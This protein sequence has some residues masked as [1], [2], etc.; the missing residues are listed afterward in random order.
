M[1]AMSMG[2]AAPEDVFIISDL[3]IGGQYGK[4][5][6][7]RGFRINTHVKELTGFLTEVR[8]RA[9]N[10]RRRTELVINGDFVDFLAEG[11]ADG[12]DW[13]AF[14][15]SEDEAIARLDEIV[16]RD[17]GLFESVA[18]LLEAGVAVTL[19]PGNHDIEL[20]VP[21][22][23]ARLREHL[24]ATRTSGFQFVYDGEAYV[25]GDTL[26]E[27]GN[28]Y[29][30]FNV[31][32]YDILRRYRSESSRR[33]PMSVD[34]TFVA[35]PGSQLVEQ[36]MNPIKKEYGFIDLLKPENDAAIP[37]L[38]ALEP[39]L[40][41]DVD[42]IHT[43]MQL[44]AEAQ[45]RNPIA[46]ATP[47]QPGNIRATGG[48]TKKGTETLQQLLQRR[49]GAAAAMQLMALVNEAE[50][51]AQQKERQISAGKI[52]R[53]LSFARMLFVEKE[54]EG[55]VALLLDGFR[56]IQ[57]AKLFD[58]SIESELCYR[59]AAEE[60]A[61]GGF[62][63]ISFGHTHMPKNVELP[64]GAKYLNTGAWADR[65]RVP[66]TV[67]LEPRERGFEALK[68]FATA[69]KN[70]RFEEYVEFLPT[71]AYIKSDD[72]GHSLPGTVQQYEPGLVRDL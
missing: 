61:R 9:T 6:G 27:H 17:A 33:L 36:V 53:A 56:Q 19:L 43:V 35:P 63:N 12:T 14:I 50:R 48:N 1:M 59:E 11:G 10:R 4:A 64:G 65:M 51:Q 70:N 34:A 2:G 38:L 55:R 29:D 52:G 30:G 62:R 21:A 67:F 49:I 16:K 7:D 31:V 8:E 32:D 58:W 66:Q 68:K 24:R 71:F 46:A 37:L 18:S 69:I 5:P 45:S 26:I 23:R 28:R 44:Q 25:I 42:R 22:V 39:A 60:L 40:A 72:H 41:R 13:R 3:H 15:E 57:D 47:A 54:W 20:T